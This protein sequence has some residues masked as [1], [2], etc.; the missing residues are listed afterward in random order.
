MELAIG[1]ED[2]PAK[3]D[4]LAPG[5][6][7]RLPSA[8]NVD[9]SRCRSDEHV[10]LDNHV[11]DQADGRDQPTTLESVA[12]AE[13]ISLGGDH[14]AGIAADVVEEV[15]S[16]EHVSAWIPSLVAETIGPA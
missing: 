3:G 11:A 8:E 13:V 2:V 5:I 9:R 7:L 12:D 10:V 14:Y 15:V 16:H 4:L 6:L 1:E